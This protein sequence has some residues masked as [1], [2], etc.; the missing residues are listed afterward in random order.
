MVWP[1]RNMNAGFSPALLVLVVLTLPGAAPAEG[2]FPGAEPSRSAIKS[3]AKADQLYEIGRFER[4]LFIYKHDLASIGDKYAQYMIGYMYLSGQGV[5]EDPIAASA[6]YRLAAER[7]YESFVYASEALYGTLDKQQRELS[8]RAFLELRRQFGDMWI[9][10]RMLESDIQ[11]LAGR[12]PLR[13]IV[14][15]QNRYNVAGNYQSEGYYDDVVE[16]MSRRSEY[17]E[18]LLLKDAWIPDPD[19]ES[20][21]ALLQRARQEADS[22]FVE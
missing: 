18:S 21:E 19:R 14:E 9:V 20:F 4:A 10:G 8:D 3:Q 6:W 2:R 15:P 7:G 22:Y 12:D 1:T 16:R 5:T 13:A 17:L 11:T